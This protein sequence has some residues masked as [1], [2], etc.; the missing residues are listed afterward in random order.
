MH[1]AFGAILATLYTRY[2]LL[3][4]KHFPL[5]PATAGWYDENVAHGHWGHARKQ[6]RMS[7]DD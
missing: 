3:K 1:G 4:K 7:H 2:G 5:D 6:G